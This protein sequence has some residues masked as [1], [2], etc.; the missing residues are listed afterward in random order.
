MGKLHVIDT[1]PPPEN[2]KSFDDETAETLRREAAGF[3]LQ[4]P[5]DKDKALAVLT[6]AR[7]FLQKFVWGKGS[8][9][10]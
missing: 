1:S 6:Y 9:E 10:G 2:L 7:L 4:L 3:A 5:P 8:T